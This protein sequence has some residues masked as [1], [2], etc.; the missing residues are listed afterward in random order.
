MLP[1]CHLGAFLAV[2]PAAAAAGCLRSHGVQ[3]PTVRLT[4]FI[5]AETHCSFSH[6][7][8]VLSS[9][10][11]GSVPCRLFWLWT[12]RRAGLLVKPSSVPLCALELLSSTITSGASGFAKPHQCRCISE[13]PGNDNAA[14]SVILQPIPFV[15]F[16]CN[17]I[18]LQRCDRCFVADR[19][20]LIVSSPGGYSIE[21]RQTDRQ[22]LCV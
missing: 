22:T 6:S 9:A 10:I 17:S 20:Q 5:C 7:G 8:L 3:G 19:L 13:I 1:P 21:S 12:V 15:S 2:A 11:G 14:R 18:R 16:V 4:T